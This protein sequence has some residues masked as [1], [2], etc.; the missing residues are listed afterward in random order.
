MT[1]EQPYL[2]V[3]A[4]AK[5]RGHDIHGN[6]EY[7]APRGSR[8]HKGIDL[9]CEGGT[10]IMSACDGVV[11][12]TRGIVYSDPAKSFWHYIEVM[13]RNGVQNRYFYVEQWEIQPGQ[14]VMKGEPIGVAQGI[15]G[16]YPGITPHIHYEVRKGK[17]DYLNPVEYLEGLQ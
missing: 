16:Q 12:R 11:T 9:V 8:T 14:H 7:G 4:T 17:N 10:M 2:H 13:D 1:G 15:E 5:I 3:T 6:G